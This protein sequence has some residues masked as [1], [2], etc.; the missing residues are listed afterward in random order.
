VILWGYSNMNSQEFAAKVRAKYPGA[1]DNIDDNTLTQKVIEKYPVYKDSVTMDDEPSKLG[2][3]ARGAMSGIP[4]AETVVS[5]IQALSPDVT[6]EQAHKDLETAKDKDWETNPVSYG[7]GKGAG[8]VGTALATGGAGTGLKGAM[9]LGAGFGA[10]SGAD[11]AQNLSDIPMDAV[12]GAPMGAAVGLLGHGVGKALEAAP[13]LAKGVLSKFGKETNVADISK[14]LENPGSTNNAIDKTAIGDKA[15]SLASD[16]GKAAGHL[17]GE[18]RG[19]LSPAVTATTM[20]DLEDVFQNTA[21]PYFRNGQVKPG[22]E[23]AVKALENEF[24][25]IH[26]MA[27]ENGGKIDEVLLRGIVDDLQAA[28]KVGAAFGDADANAKEQALKTISGKLNELL[29]TTN[30]TGYADAMAPAAEATNV[31]KDLQKTLALESG[32]VTDATLGKLNNITKE[33]KPETADLMNKIKDMTGQDLTAM[34]EDA[35]M[36]AR[37]QAPGSGAAMKTLMSGLGFGLGHM[38]GIPGGGIGG[39][40]LGRF[41]A[42]S[43]DGGAVAK[44]IMDMYLN[45]ANRP[46]S[47]AISSALDKFGPI[48]ARA[49]KSG[50]NQLASTHFVLA[51]SNPEYQQVIA[52]IQNSGE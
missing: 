49:A 14:Y 37:F 23:P 40:A 13:G 19:T 43:V 31:S 51:T 46:T 15:A 6:Y 12:K 26:G 17:S 44:K 29:R 16:L 4:G 38:T 8:M 36:K 7:T 35:N 32:K 3:F 52:H 20:R 50:G 11:E 48:L 34:L 10:L 21:A 39:A 1:Y 18:A 22:M 24:I 42:E 28:P 25:R 30:K 2:S 9:A 45:A 27:Q 5:G 33:G 47:Q 41:A